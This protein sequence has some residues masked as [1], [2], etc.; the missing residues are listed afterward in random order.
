MRKLLLLLFLFA[1][2]SGFS[3]PGSKHPE[4]KIRQKLIIN[5]SILNRLKLFDDS[6]AKELHKK[7]ELKQIEENSQKNPDYI[8]QLQKERRE[9]EKRNSIIPIVIGAVLFIV[10]IFGLRRRAKK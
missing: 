6:I 1:F 9:K 8:L 10:L 4:G 5:D 3:Q 2:I 7:A